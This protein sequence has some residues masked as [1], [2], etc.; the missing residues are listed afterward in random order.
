MFIKTNNGP[1]WVIWGDAH[2][3]LRRLCTVCR[4]LSHLCLQQTE[5]TYLTK[6]GA[7]LKPKRRLDLD[8]PKLTK[9][10]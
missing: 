2:S 8:T 7:D 4:N 5:A 3:G 6:F 9:S 1:H 10:T